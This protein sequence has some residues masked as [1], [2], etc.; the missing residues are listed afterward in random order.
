LPATLIE[1]ELFGYRAGARPKARAS[2][3]GLVEAAD[4]GT[5]LL[6]EVGSMPAELQVKIFRLLQD[7]TITRVDVRVIGTTTHLDAAGDLRAMRADL[8]ARLGADP[9]AIPPLRDRPEDV[10]GLVAHFAAGAFD[11]VEPAALRALCLYGWPLNARELQKVAR[12]AMALAD[13]R[14]LRLEQ[15][16]AVIQAA[17][18]RGPLVTARRSPRAAPER[19]ELEYLLREHDG[20]VTDV[21]RALDRKWGVVWRWLVRLGLSPEKFRKTKRNSGGGDQG[22]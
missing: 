21:G 22:L 4:G 15:L 14:E 9:I 18:S 6:D 3:P 17:L 5:L 20:N 13:G 16:P 8:V 1:R 12:N 10:P 7:R 19:A 11:K 2:K